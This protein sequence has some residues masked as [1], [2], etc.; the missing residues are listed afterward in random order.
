MKLL[1]E[2]NKLR[3]CP[4]CKGGGLYAVGDTIIECSRCRGE[5]IVD[6]KVSYDR[7]LLIIEFYLRNLDN[8]IVMDIVAA[9]NTTHLNLVRMLYKHKIYV[10]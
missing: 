10:E 8:M 5:G 3:I 2:M 7:E 1:G 6:D 9:C 4:R